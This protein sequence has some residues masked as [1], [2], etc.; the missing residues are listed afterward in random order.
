MNRSAELAQLRSGAPLDLLVIGG[1]IAGAG[2]AL[3]AARAGL[4][5]ALVEARDFASGTSSRSSKLVHGGLR[6]LAQGRLGLTRESLHERNALLREAAGLVRPLRFLLPVRQG[7]RNGRHLLGLGLTVYDTLA[8][9]RTR[10]WRTVAELLADAP[11]IEQDGLIGGWSYLDAQADDARLVMRVLAEARHLGAGALNHLRVESLTLAA[12]KVNGAT[13]HDALSDERFQVSARC[14]VNATGAWADK[15]RAQVGR[16]PVMRPLRGSHLLLP[17]WR[18]PVAQAVAFFHPRDGRPVYALPWEGATLVGTTDLDHREDLEQEPGIARAEFDYLLDALRQTF[19]SLGLREADVRST[20]SGVRPV[21]GSGQ[22]VDPSKETR[23]HLIVDEDGL[24]TVTG[25]KLTTFRS[26]ALLVLKE[27]ARYIPALAR[28]RTDGDIFAAVPPAAAAALEALPRG[29]RSRW[30][31]RFGALAPQVLQAAREGELQT[32]A[33]TDIAWAELRWACRAEA[34]AHLDDLLLRR[35]RLGLLLPL[36]ADDR[37][38][39]LKPLVQ[40][41]LGWDDERWQLECERYRAIIAHCYSIPPRVTDAP[42]E[43]IR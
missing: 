1:G 27:A 41:E 11:G 6:Y 7:D 24:L 30:L 17:D 43:V 12:G 36:G 34:V 38:R 10:Q 14:V 15:L 9:Q 13:L 2:V 4:R 29:Q 18:L 21:V 39:D 19:P 22:S 3:E 16:Q 8:G 25:G 37:L 42:V 26:T 35:T 31:A 33:N 28:M 40:E 23:E 5:V 32:I 20:W